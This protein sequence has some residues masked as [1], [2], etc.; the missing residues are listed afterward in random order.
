VGKA[1]RCDG[2][3]G[4]AAVTRAETRR[5]R[6]DARAAGAVRY[7]TGLACARGHIAE[8]FVS[9]AS[10]T[11]CSRLDAAAERDRAHVKRR[12]VAKTRAAAIAAGVTHFRG[13][14]CKRGHHGK[15]RVA[16]GACVE[17][18]AAARHAASRVPA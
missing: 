12:G 16:T 15:R 4:V 6:D 14:P 5:L 7:F 9:D 13:R 8:R 3:R 11:E 17:C 18:E 1:Q 10:C 2:I